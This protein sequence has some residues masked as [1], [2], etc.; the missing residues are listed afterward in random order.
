MYSRASAKVVGDYG[1]PAGTGVATL[2]FEF[3]PH[4]SSEMA[5][6]QTDIATFHAAA[7]TAQLTDTKIGDIQTAVVSENFP[8]KPALDVNIDR[9]LVYS[10][11]TKNDAHIHRGTIHGVPASS[12]SITKFPEGERLNET[13]KTALAGALEALYQIADPNEVI[14]LS[15]KV[16]QKS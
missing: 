4:D 13:G 14:I 5:T 9:V 6:L 3:L 12:T 16:V 11:R 2:S 1:N 15:G 10:W 7:K 8:T